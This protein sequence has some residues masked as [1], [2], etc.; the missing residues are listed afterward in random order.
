MKILSINVG[1]IKPLIGPASSPAGQNAKEVKS[2]IYKH[3]VSDQSRPEPQ[4]ITS[5]GLVG[6]EQANLE[7]HGGRDKAL[8]AYPFEHYGFWEE[9]LLREKKLN[10]K[11]EYGTFG[12]NLTV[13]GFTEKDVFVG[14]RWRV[15]TTLLE[16]VKFREPCFK[17]N[18]KMGWS[19][20]AKAMIQSNTSGWYLR[21]LEE[22]SIQ[23][24]DSV[25]VIPGNRQLSIFIQCA[26]FYNQSAQKDMWT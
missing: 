4:K 23:A 14:D 21:V 10:T 3:S 8:Y 25:Q 13:E 2:A 7:V 19:G 26:S 16:V 18:I 12:E 5:L 22:G 11:L 1:Q 24:G 15:G 17:F 6:D 9:C 20:A